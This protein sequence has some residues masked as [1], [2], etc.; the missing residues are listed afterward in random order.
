MSPVAPRCSLSRRTRTV[1]LLIAGLALGAG[2]VAAIAAPAQVATPA[3]ATARSV[4]VQL[5]GAG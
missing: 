4:T 1:A 5:T 2:T 3:P